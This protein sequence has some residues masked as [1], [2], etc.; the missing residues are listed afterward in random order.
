MTEVLDAL[1]P[2]GNSMRDLLAI[3]PE[4]TDILNRRTPASYDVFTNQIDK[5]LNNII[6]VTESG[7]QHHYDKSEDEL[8]EHLIVQLKQNYSS[9]HHDAQHG[10]HC[11][12]YIETK[13]SNG[14]LY[15]WIMEAKLWNGFEYV[16]SGLNDQ[17][18][19]SYAVSGANN[20]KGGIIF[21]SQQ[22]SG[23]KFFMDKWYDGLREKGI[24]INN[25]RSDGLRF[26]TT[27]KL[28]SGT[29]GDFSVNHYCVDLY[30]APTAAK[31]AKAK[32]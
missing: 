12:I 1:I 2:K 21:Y 19:G 26:A 16:Y 31:L 8:T 22:P 32:K 14:E 3:S 30:H 23:A 13:G 20:C 24:N 27:H 10:G 17:L 29:G 28:N 4:I 9:V 18:L 6:S 5:D 11:D 25:K 7:R 15:K